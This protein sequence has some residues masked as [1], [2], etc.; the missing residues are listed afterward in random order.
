MVKCSEIKCL[1]ACPPKVLATLF[2]QTFAV[3]SKVQISALLFV[4]LIP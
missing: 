4:E 3:P 2:V 1:H